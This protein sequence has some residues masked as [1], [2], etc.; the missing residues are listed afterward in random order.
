MALATKLGIKPPFP[1]L[2]W[3]LLK[4]EIF[5]RVLEKRTPGRA[6]LIGREFYQ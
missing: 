1:A 5:S 3:I 4:Q 6:S 2:K